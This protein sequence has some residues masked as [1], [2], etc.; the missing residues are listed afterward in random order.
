MDSPP[1]VVDGWDPLLAAVE[2]QD[3]QRV[4]SLLQGPEAYKLADKAVVDGSVPPKGVPASDWVGYTPLLLAANRGATEVVDA[5][6]GPATVNLGHAPSGASAV[7][8]ASMKGHLDIV[9]ILTDKG[10]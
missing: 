2:A 1:D 10:A 5:L 9:Q 3:V 4:K 8:L 7:F 6:T